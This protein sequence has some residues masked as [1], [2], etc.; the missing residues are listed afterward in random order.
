VKG[1]KDG[2]MKERQGE[3][4]KTERV[5]DRKGGRVEGWKFERVD[6]LKGGS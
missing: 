5:T 3:R 1:W 6:G 2:R 4:K